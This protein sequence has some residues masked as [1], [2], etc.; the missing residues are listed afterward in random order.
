[1]VEEFDAL[2][3]VAHRFATLA[4]GVVADHAQETVAHFLVSEEAEAEAIL[5]LLEGPT[6]WSRLKSLAGKAKVVVAAN[7][8][9]ELA[10]AKYRVS[11]NL[12]MAM[13]TTREQA[14]RR[15]GQ[16]HQKVLTILDFHWGP[17]LLNL[18]LNL[19]FWKK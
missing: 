15:N 1:M 7:S 6:D 9:K 2:L 12:L 3:P 10:D 17:P 14:D 13:Q 16:R 11:G 8:T 18:K 19:R 4:Q 5:L